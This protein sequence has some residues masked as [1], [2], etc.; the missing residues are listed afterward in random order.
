MLV[1]LAIASFRLGRHIGEDAVRLR[2]PAVHPP[3]LR[4]GG[5]RHRLIPV[6][7]RSRLRGVRIVRRARRLR[8]RR[9]PPHKPLPVVALIL[10]LVVVAERI[11]EVRVHASP[12]GGRRAGVEGRGRGVRYRVH[13]ARG[14]RRPQVVRVV[15]DHLSRRGLAR[16]QGVSI[17][18]GERRRTLS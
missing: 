15:V 10:A 6:P 4:P 2:P 18:T 5:L 16:R 8:G 1:L 14:G 3:R 7:I 13:L 11:R 17:G 9:V 12:V